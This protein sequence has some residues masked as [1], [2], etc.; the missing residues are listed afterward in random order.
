VAS[1]KSIIPS[2]FA[3]LVFPLTSQLVVTTNIKIGM[4]TNGTSMLPATENLESTSNRKSL[5]F[6]PASRLLVLIV[7]APIILSVALDFATQNYQKHP[8]S[9]FS[10]IQK[11]PLSSPQKMAADTN[12]AKVLN[13]HVVPHTHDD[14]GWLKTVDEYFYGLNQ[15]I[16]QVS[17]KDI[18]DSVVASLLEN[19]SRTFTYVEIKFFSM[20]W[21]LQ[22][23]AVRDSVRFLIANKQLSFVNGGWCM[24]DEATTHYMG[25]VDS[26]TRGRCSDIVWKMIF[27]KHFEVDDNS[28]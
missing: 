2:S 19:P 3:T 10:G 20:W 27:Y 7:S 17:V 22:S 9:S 18:L 26:T 5:S 13:V 11:G 12:N 28:S 25:M 16:Q 6:R 1:G 24:H 4:K 8:E 21:E 15:T 23:D 14:T